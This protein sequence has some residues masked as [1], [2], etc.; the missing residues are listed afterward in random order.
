MVSRMRIWQMAD[1]YSA[2]LQRFA[3]TGVSEP[4]MLLA[5]T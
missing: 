4:K 5:R 2:E 1:D 3:V